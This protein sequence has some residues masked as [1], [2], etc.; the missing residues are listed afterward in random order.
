M[1][2]SVLDPSKIDFKSLFLKSRYKIPPRHKNGATGK[3]GPLRAI[4]ATKLLRQIQAVLLL[5]AP[6]KDFKK[7]NLFY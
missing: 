2:V 7:M 1:D 4:L 5:P 3:S 6:Y